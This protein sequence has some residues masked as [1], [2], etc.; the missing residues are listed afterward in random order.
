MEQEL[1][2]IE[3]LKLKQKREIEQIVSYELKMNQI[4]KRNEDK[5]I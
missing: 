3:L 5:A 2:A 4:K 1:A